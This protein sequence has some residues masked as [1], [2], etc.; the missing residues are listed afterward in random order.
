MLR[1]R[2]V[3]T[4][5]TGPR[6]APR[7]KDSSCEGARCYDCRQIGL[8]LLAIQRST[9]YDYGQDKSGRWMGG[10][11]R[12]GQKAWLFRFSERGFE[13][14]SRARSPSFAAAIIRPA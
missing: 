3:S 7:L 4:F 11:S 12:V 10:L 14:A 13:Q 6:V 5:H 2:A 8:P 1:A 9:P